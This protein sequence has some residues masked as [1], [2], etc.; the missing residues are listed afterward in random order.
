M[1]LTAS[2]LRHC[3]NP[4]LYQDSSPIGTDS[5]SIGSRS[6]ASSVQDINTIP[7]DQT[8]PSPSRSRA[9]PAYEN[10]CRRPMTPPPLSMDERVVWISDSGPEL[11]V[12]RWIGILPD[13]KVKEYTIGVEF[14]SICM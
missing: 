2:K 14:V 5:Q 4:K 13:V 9:E 6:S 3:D 8:M 10:V 7:P 1:F 12:V 11:G